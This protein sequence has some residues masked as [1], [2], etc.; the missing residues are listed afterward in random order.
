M[1]AGRHYGL[2]VHTCVRFDPE[3][4]GGSE[5]TVRIAKADLVPINANLVRRPAGRVACLPRTGDPEGQS[6]HPVRRGSK[7]PLDFAQLIQV[8]C[9]DYVEASRWHA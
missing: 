6:G 7:F 8:L 2:T 5:A 4:K 3:S 9:R 1:S